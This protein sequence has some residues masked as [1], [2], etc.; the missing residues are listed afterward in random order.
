[1]LL[2]ILMSRPAWLRYDFYLLN[3]VLPK[4]NADRYS[5]KLHLGRRM[6]LAFIAFNTLCCLLIPAIKSSSII[7]FVLT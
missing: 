3:S 7:R 2:L 1:M 5:P 6:L 4:G